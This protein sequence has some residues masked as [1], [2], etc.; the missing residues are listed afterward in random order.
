MSLKICNFVQN[1]F[2]ELEYLT[3]VKIFPKVEAILDSIPL[4]I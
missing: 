4:V 1:I 2:R 3:A